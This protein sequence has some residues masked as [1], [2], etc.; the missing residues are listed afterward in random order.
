M[1][2]F[3]SIVSKGVLEMNKALQKISNGTQNIEKLMERRRWILPSILSVV[4]FLVAIWG[5]ENFNQLLL[6]DDE[7]GYWM[8]SAYL[9]GTDWTSVGSGIPYYSYGYGFLVLTPIR[10]LFSNPSTMYQAAIVVN[11][12]LLVASY[13]IARNVTKQLF[14]D[15]NWA[16]VDVVCF[17][18]MLYPSNIVFS[19]IA[20]AECTLVF[21]FWVFVWLSL[22]VIKAPTLYNHI[23]L[24]CVVMGLYVVHQRTLAVAIATVMVMAWCFYVDKSRRKNILVF[25][26]VMVVLMV[27]HTLI[28]TDLQNTFY[29]N[30]IKIEKNELE[31]QTEKI[32]SIFTGEGFVLFLESV[33]GKWFYLFSATFMMAWWSAEYLFKNAFSHVTDALKNA[34][35][36]KKKEINVDTTFW[37]MWVLLAFG[38]SFMIEAIY[39]IGGGRNDMLLYGRYVEHMIGIYFIIGIFAFLRDEK[40]INK[41]VSYVFITIICGWICQNVLNRDNATAYQAYHSISTSLFLEKGVS[42]SGAVLGYATLSIAIS[43]FVMLLIK[44]QK[45]KRVEWMRRT[46]IVCPILLLFVNIAFDMIFGVMTEKQLLRIVNIQNIVGWVEQ[47]DDELEHKVYYCSDTESRYWSESFQ[48][49]LEDN[50]ITVI[51]STD[52]DVDEDA[53]YIVGRN[54]VQLDGFD[55]YFYCIKESN[56]FALIINKYG[57]LAETAKEIK[58]E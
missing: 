25:A 54:Y 8:A 5:I 22:R 48:F 55:D 53:F 44:G 20:W 52:I 31:G 29:L 6:Y 51:K 3:C 23:G 34:K 26:G 1:L 21:V 38:G 32:A 13:W 11:A 28:K 17:V 35:S 36:K 46:L 33:V 47:V 41:A 4:L 10:L 24:A 2:K 58:G 15:V 50:P 18:V 14:A 30:N 56:Q 37:Y 39:M 9:T 19:H 57:E 12:L 40:W 16:L 43:L 45:W 7:F 42:A 49:L 27:V